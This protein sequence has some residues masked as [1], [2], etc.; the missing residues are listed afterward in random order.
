MVFSEPQVHRQGRPS[1]S[2]Y[3]HGTILDEKGQ[4]MSKSKGNGIDPIEMIEKYGADAVR[5]ALM[6]LTTE[7]QDIKL[8][9]VKFETG[10]QLRQQAVERGALRAPAPGSGPRG[11][12]QSATCPPPA[13]TRCTWRTAGYWD[14]WTRPSAR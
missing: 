9:P 7:G 10:P 12:R 6:I 5:F 14:A 1:I 13:A 4:R 3:I 11:R 2:V 8:S